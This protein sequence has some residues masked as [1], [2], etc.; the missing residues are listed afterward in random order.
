L[1]ELKTQIGDNSYILLS[2]IHRYTDQSFILVDR[3]GVLANLYGLGNVAYVGGS[4]KQ[5]IHNVLEAAVY[6]IPVLFGPVNQNSHE[7][8]LLKANQGGFE[9]RNAAALRLTIERFIRNDIYRQECGL[10]AFA[11]V[12]RNLGATTKT[13]QQLLYFIPADQKSPDFS[14]TESKTS[15]HS[16]TE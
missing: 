12:E 4:F 3:I 11:I 10:K 14:R 15:A 8:Q 9:V 7:A 6:R 13:I 5:N 16:K 2:E 1:D